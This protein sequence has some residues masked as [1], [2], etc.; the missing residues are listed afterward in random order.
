MMD[1]NNPVIQLC[2]QGTQAEYARQ[3]EQAAHFC[4]RAWQTAKTDY[5]RC[6]AAHYLARSQP[7]AHEVLH[8]N[9]LALQHAQLVE[10]PEEV[11]AFLPSMYLALGAALEAMGEIDEAQAFYQ[12]ASQAGLNHSL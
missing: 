7:S 12:L 8:W 9:R 11:A 1:T 2:I 10:D 4:L 3:P 5:E 6:I